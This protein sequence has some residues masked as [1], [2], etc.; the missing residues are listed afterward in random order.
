MKIPVAS[1]D[2]PLESNPIYTQ[3][4]LLL[5]KWLEVIQKKT[6]GLNQRYIRFDRVLNNSIAFACV[7]QNYILL[8]LKLV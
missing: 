6:T 1:F 7:I 8:E 2:I 4:E 3:Q 5:F